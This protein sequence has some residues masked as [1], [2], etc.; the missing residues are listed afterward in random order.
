MSRPY[1]YLEVERR[2]DVFCVRLRQSRLDE[3]MIHE[4]AGELRSLVEEQSCRRMA[5][6]LGPDSPECL[7]SVFLAKLIS[8]NRVLREH[9]G[10]LLLCEVAPVVRD[11]FAACCLERLF[12]FVPDFGAAVKHWTA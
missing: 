4:L 7:Y 9:D 11:I 6:S 1:R 3:A 2:A 5:L 10:E 12:H 8:L